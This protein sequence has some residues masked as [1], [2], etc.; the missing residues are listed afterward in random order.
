MISERRL[1]GLW[2]RYVQSHASHKEKVVREI[3][4]NGVKYPALEGSIDATGNDVWKKFTPTDEEPVVTTPQ[5][6]IPQLPSTKGEKI[7]V[8]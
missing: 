2:T 5:P 1:F 4:T 6:T 7:Y 3:T 8:K